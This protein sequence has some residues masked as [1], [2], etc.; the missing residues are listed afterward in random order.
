MNVFF[1]HTDDVSWRAPRKA[2]ESPESSTIAPIDWWGLDLHTAAKCP[3][4]LHSAHVASRAGHLGRG[5]VSLPHQEQVFACWGDPVDPVVIGP[6]FRVRWR[7][8]CFLFHGAVLWRGCQIWGGRSARWSP[9]SCLLR[10]YSF[11]VPCNGVGFLQIQVR[12][13][14]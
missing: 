4:F 2:G 5:W 12:V 6:G 14:L 1:V 7:C 9:H 10:S 8:P 11:A 3:R 13:Q